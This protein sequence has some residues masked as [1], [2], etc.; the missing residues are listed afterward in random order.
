MIGSLSWKSWLSA[1]PG[2]GGALVAKLACPACWPLYTS[3]LAAVGVRFV[4][5]TGYRVPLVALVLALALGALA[6]RGRSRRDYRPLSVGAAGA[7]ALAAGEFALH[8]EPLAIA[9]VAVLAGA[10]LWAAW[11]GAKAQETC[12]ACVVER[13]TT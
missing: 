12:D 4:S 3:A 7:L 2:V 9:G 6:L 10:S 1:V 5:P 8:S 11:P 13:R